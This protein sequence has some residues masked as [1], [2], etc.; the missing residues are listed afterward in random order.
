M[1]NLHKLA[2]HKTH[3][4]VTIQNIPEQSAGS[5]LKV[6]VK[7]G[8]AGSSEILATTYETTRYNLD[9]DNLSPTL[10]TEAAGSSKTL[11]TTYQTLCSHTTKSHNLSWRQ[12]FPLNCHQLFGKPLSH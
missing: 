12:Q 3:K 9:G 1:L 2:M 10:M 5:I 8:V 6:K 7:I 11:V 4:V